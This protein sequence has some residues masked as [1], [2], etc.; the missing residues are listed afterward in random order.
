MSRKIPITPKKISLYG[1]P[2]K[3]LPKVS[4]NTPPDKQQ[5]CMPVV[6]FWPDSKEENNDRLPENE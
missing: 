6:N 5:K 1:K 2:I 4:L 3:M